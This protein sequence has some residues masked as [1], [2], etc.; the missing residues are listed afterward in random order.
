MENEVEIKNTQDIPVESPEVESNITENIPVEQAVAD[1]SVEVIEEIKETIPST[2]KKTAMPD[3]VTKSKTVANTAPEENK[4]SN[5]RILQGKVKSNKS[6]KTILVAIVRQ[7]SHPLY[8][9]YYKRTKKVMAHDENNECKIGDT[10]KVRESRP[11]SARKRWEL[12]EIVQ[13][14]K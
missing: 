13:R 8:K 12:I 9:K 10:V 5:K 4:R 11:L 6:D 7:V 14:A 3:D 1:N 2:P